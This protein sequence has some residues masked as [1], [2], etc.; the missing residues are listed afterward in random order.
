M[1]LEIE[2]NNITGKYGFVTGWGVTENRR[3]SPELLQAQLQV[4]ELRECQKLYPITSI[5]ENNLCVGGDSPSNSC[6][7][8]SGGPFQLP[9]KFR[10]DDVR[11]VQQGI[12]SF[13]LIQNYCTLSKSP[14]V[15]VKV[16]NYVNWILSVLTT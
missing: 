1:P 15:Y 13:G 2:K 16:A 4:K 14:V 6:F 10:N 7:G 5:N 9:T 11:M 8:D 3:K 12:V